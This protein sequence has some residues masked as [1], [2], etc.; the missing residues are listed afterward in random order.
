VLEGTNSGGLPGPAMASNRNGT[1]SAGFA[2]FAGTSSPGAANDSSAGSM[3]ANHASGISESWHQVA[4]FATAEE[5]KNYM[6]AHPTGFRTGKDTRA[7]NGCVLL[8]SP[9]STELQ[10]LALCRFRGWKCKRCCDPQDVKQNPKTGKRD[11][12][13][14][15]P[16]CGITYRDG[17]HAKVGLGSATGHG[18]ALSSS[19]VTGPQHNIYEYVG[20]EIVLQR[21]RVKGSTGIHVCINPTQEMF[22]VNTPHFTPFDRLYP[23][24][25]NHRSYPAMTNH[26]LQ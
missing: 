17:V 11:Y 22:G 14:V 13:S 5:L 1:G 26:T 16:R 21:R 9:T 6:D 15:I 18:R 12:G 23:I 25:C 7:A 8:A 20:G 24:P 10:C 3:D 4:S 19:S 2:G